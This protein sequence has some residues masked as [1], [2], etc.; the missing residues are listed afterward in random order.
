MAPSEP[1]RALTAALV[2]YLKE[3]IPGSLFDGIPAMLVRELC[4]DKIADAVGVQKADWTKRLLRPMRWL[5]SWTDEA[6]D[7]SSSVA[8]I[9]GQ[10]SRK[11]IEGLHYVERG[12]KKVNFTIPKSLQDSWGLESRTKSR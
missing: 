2:G 1:G 9:S 11:L 6:Q 10:F 4:G 7:R 3:R 12:G 8:K 5:L